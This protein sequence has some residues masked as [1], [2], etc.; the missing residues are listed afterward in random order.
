MLDP[1]ALVSGPDAAA[2]LPHVTGD[3]I[4]KWSSRGYSAIVRG[5]DDQPIVGEDGKTTRERRYLEAVDHHGPRGAARYRW[6]DIVNAE[7]DTR[8]NP[9]S[10]GRGRALL[11]A[12]A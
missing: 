9:R 12:A 2:H 3:M 10:P 4:R 7:R 1:N 6:S 5:E 11:V 8:R